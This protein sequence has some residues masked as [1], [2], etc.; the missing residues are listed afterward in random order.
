MTPED[1]DRILGSQE[2]I[3]P[4]SGF[5]ASV[6]ERARE[7]ASAPPPLPFPWR[8]FLLGLLVLVAM[9]GLWGWIGVRLHVTDALGAAV[10][11]ALTA[12]AD[13]RLMRPLA[14]ATAA[15]A[16]AYVLVRLT[17]GFTG[18]RR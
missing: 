2:L 12:L 5:A 4:S 18:A 11:N 7:A 1:L 16:G 10:G 15:L 14:G 8:R 9:N 13:P 17:L 6:M 3:A